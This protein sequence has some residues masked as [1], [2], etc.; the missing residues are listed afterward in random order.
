MNRNKSDHNNIPPDRWASRGRRAVLFLK[1]YGIV[2]LIG[3][4]HS[5]GIANSF[6]YLIKHLR[7]QIAIELGKRWDRK[8]NVDTRGQIDLDEVDVVGTNKTNGHAVVSISPRTFSFLSRYFPQDCENYT[9]IDIGSG[10]GRGLLMAQKYGFDKIVG[11]EFVEA[12]CSIA[13]DNIQRFRHGNGRVSSGDVVHL[14]A[15][16]FEYPLENLVLYF[17]NPFSTNVWE[18]IIP[19]IEASLQEKPRKIIFIMVGSVPDK[20]E[21]VIEMMGRSSYFV[22]RARGI[23]PYYWDTYLPFYYAVYKTP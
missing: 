18:I 14:D 13:K 23:S 17:N 16:Q 22:L 21:A 8:H 6:A 7:Y 12:V 5:Y 4:V 10:K 15:T 3:R 20:V 9:F 1:Q 19:M 11:V 2:G